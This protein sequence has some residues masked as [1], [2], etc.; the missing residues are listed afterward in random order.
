MIGFLK[1]F[2]SNIHYKYS[3][4]P[5]PQFTTG[6]WSVYD[7]K[8]KSTNEPVSVL[9][10]SKK[11]VAK[12][13]NRNGV[14]LRT[15]MWEEVK[16]FATQG[17]HQL[18]KIRH[19][20]VVKVVEPIESSKGTLTFV[21]ERLVSTVQE[22]RESDLDEISVV[23]GVTTITQALSFLH[24]SIGVV[25]LNITPETVL[26]DAQGD[27]KLMGMEFVTT[28]E[29]HTPGS[30]Y[31]PQRDP[32]LPYFMH[33]ALDFLAPE[34]VMEKICV[35]ANDVWGIASLLYFIYIR[36]PPLSTRGN[37]NAYRDEYQRFRTKLS[38]ISAKFPAKLRPYLD[39]LFSDNYEG[40]ITIEILET[41]DFFQNPLIKAL[42]SLDEYQA[43]P[44]EE[45][46]S[47]LKHLATLIPHFP[48][49]IRLRKIV[50]FAVNELSGPREP[51]TG[52]L[53]GNT[54]FA[55]ANDMSSLS[56]TDQILPI[57]SKITDYL[58]FQE[59][60]AANV[61]TIV[62]ATNDKDF[63]KTVLPLFVDALKHHDAQ[64]V[65]LQTI[66]LKST[67]V[68]GKNLTV[69]KMEQLLFPAVIDCFAATPARSVKVAAT[70]S[71]SVLV[72]RGVSKT[73]IM[74]RLIPA[75]QA[76]KTRD[77]AVVVSVS[78]LW[79]ALC[80]RLNSEQIFTLALPHLLDCALVKQFTVDQFKQV[81]LIIQEQIDSVQKNQIK[82]LANNK[83]D[84]TDDWLNDTTPPISS[85]SVPSEPVASTSGISAE[86]PATL[87]KPVAKEPPTL[88]ESA[89]SVIKSTKK[90]A[91]L[92]TL[93]PPKV[94]VK[95]SGMQAMVPQSK[96]N[97]I[98]ATSKPQQP[99]SLMQSSSFMA[100]L[101]PSNKSEPSYMTPM[102]PDRS[103]KPSDN[104]T[105]DDFGDFTSSNQVD[106]LI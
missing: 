8:N 29:D 71:L 101:V 27:W 10:L 25:H 52:Q 61:E 39:S 74:D 14:E 2:T 84:D 6:C 58:P 48:K 33:P 38:T 102:Q 51:A 5:S 80:P 59:S 65:N 106:S 91:P 99:P 68:Y 55:A 22:I 86:A 72:D 47:F 70:E 41:T 63:S 96:G 17:V 92:P 23:R 32:R 83:P 89:P 104:S 67:P 105:N 4:Q 90:T 88:L 76:M 79:Q 94:G 50:R 12:I 40:R 9:V 45:K 36:K 1:S 28:F 11:S 3:T 57:F 34:L 42:K 49:Q 16:A 64:H 75:L 7:A 21:T 13:M 56:F 26:V 35:P 81:M 46:V 18:T 24:S 15:S 37:P 98:Q 20:G 69:S 73:L 54:L 62:R 82:L 95:S 103:I 60:V 87:S 66:I 97:N 43:K 85:S 100:P 30:F 44:V 78:K 53:M 93:P 77:T 31:L 19:P